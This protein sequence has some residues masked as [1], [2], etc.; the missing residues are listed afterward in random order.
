MGSKG[1][2]SSELERAR[3]SGIPNGTIV[4][5]GLCYVAIWYQ[6]ADQTTGSRDV[7][8]GCA[9]TRG[10]IKDTKTQYHHS[11]RVIKYEKNMYLKGQYMA[12]FMGS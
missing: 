2:T 9:V 4:K 5:S 8:G 7:R 10:T 6:P 11:I 12:S 1:N 3:R